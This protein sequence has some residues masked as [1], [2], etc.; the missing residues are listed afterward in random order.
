MS[1]SQC[2][3]LTAVAA[4]Q[5]QHELRREAQRVHTARVAASATKASTGGRWT[6]LKRATATVSVVSARRL[7]GA[8]R[9][10]EV[11]L[12]TWRT[13]PSEA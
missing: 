1:L 12:S 10:I 5:R 7:S 9:R 2:P 4:H 13:T 6:Q 3:H 8:A 11:R